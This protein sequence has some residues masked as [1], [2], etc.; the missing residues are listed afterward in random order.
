MRK[1]F[2]LLFL[3]I[4]VNVYGAPP[5][6]DNSYTSGDTIRSA[7]VTANEDA[8]FNYLSAGVDTYAAGSIDN[9]DVNASAAIQS[10]KL[11]LTSIAQDVAITSAGSFDNNGV[12]QFDGTLTCSAAAVFNGDVTLGDGTDDTLTINSDDGITFTPAAS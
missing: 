10:D 9:A 12:S 7:D 1:L 3:F 5:S 8:I 6:R 11:T 4:T 2:I